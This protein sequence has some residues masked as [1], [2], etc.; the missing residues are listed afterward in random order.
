MLHAHTIL[1]NIGHSQRTIGVQDPS[2][3]NS[4]KTGVLDLV[5]MS[6]RRAG[7]F[8]LGT[9]SGDDTRALAYTGDEILDEKM[10]RLPY[11]D[12]YFELTM[13]DMR[14]ATLFIDLSAQKHVLQFPPDFDPNAYKGLCLAMSFTAKSQRQANTWNTPVGGLV[15]DQDCDILFSAGFPFKDVSEEERE[16][17]DDFNKHTTEM[18]LGVAAALLNAPR[19]KLEKEPAPFKLNKKR[20]ER[21]RPP[22]FEHHILKISGVSSTGKAVPLGGTHA[23]PRKHWRR[24]H[25]RVYHRNSLKEKKTL[26]PACLVNGRGFVSKDYEVA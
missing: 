21:G 14:R 7:K 19:V 16:A 2:Y 5:G 6:L 20:A 4:M 24:G 9:F 3:I 15:L 8:D 11:P 25:V 18:I 22:L 26:I 17:L 1:E 23:S 13:E 10:F 12:S